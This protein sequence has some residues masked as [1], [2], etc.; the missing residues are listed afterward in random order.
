MRCFGF[1]GDNISPSFLF[2]TETSDGSF[3]DALATSFK[4]DRSPS[5]S[6]SLHSVE[7]FR[8]YLASFYEREDYCINKGVN[9]FS[10]EAV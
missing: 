6:S 3:F 8:Q 2:M 9:S 10:K 1:G 5:S 7:C 4:A